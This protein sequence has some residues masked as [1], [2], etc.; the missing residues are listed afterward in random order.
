MV[1]RQFLVQFFRHPVSSDAELGY[2]GLR[3]LYDISVNDL[4]MALQYFVRWFQVIDWLDRRYSYRDAMIY[5]QYDQVLQVIFEAIHNV[6]KSLLLLM[7]YH[8]Y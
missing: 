6:G 8:L 3:R 2:L 5:T 1:P 7:F 4:T